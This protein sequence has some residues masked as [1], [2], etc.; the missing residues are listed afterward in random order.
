MMN[1]V[2]LSL[3]FILAST[4]LSFGQTETGTITGIVSDPTG[5]VIPSAKVVVKNR[6]TNASRTASTNS[7][8]SYTFASL[9]AGRYLVSAEFQGFANSQ[10]AVEL[11]LG[12][13]IGLDIQ[14]AVGQTGTTIEVS[15]AVAT[16]NTESQT[17]SE[18]VS[19]RQLLELPSISRDPYAVV[20]T[21]GNVSN[22]TPDGRGVGYSINGQ[23]AASTN[24]L[25]DGAANNDEFGALRGAT[26]PL[27]AVQELTVVT[28]NFTAE[29]GRA[30][31]G[32]VN[33]ATKGGTNQFHGTAYEFNRLSALASNSF[34]NNANSIAKPVFTRNQFG[35]SVGGPVLK[36]KLFFFNN[37][38]WIRVRSAGT[39]NVYVPTPQLLALAAPATQQFFSTFGKLSPNA[40]SLGTFSR[41]DLQSRGFDVCK[42]LAA[43][44]KCAAVALNTPIFQREAFNFPKDSGGGAPQNTYLTVGRV[45]YNMSEKTQMFVRYSLSNE[46][47][48][49]GTISNS[50]YSG[51]NTPNKQSNNSVVYSLTKTLSPS[52]VSQSK[53]DF[54]RFNNQQPY[55]ATYANVPTLFLTTGGGSILGDNTAFPGYGYNSPG[56]GIP[57]GGPQNFVQLYQD[58]SWTKGRHQVRAGG[59]YTY[60]RDNRVFGAYQNAGEVLGTTVPNGFENLLS[61]QLYSFTAAVDPQGKFPCGATVTASCTLS[62]PVGQPDFSRSNRYNDYALYAQDSWKVARRVTLNL[63]VRWEVFGTQHNKNPL[64][65]SNYYF[66]ANVALPAAIANGQVLLAPNSPNGTL[67]NT[68]MGNWAPRLGVAWDVFGDGSTSLRAGYGIGYERN[69][70]N[71][72]FNIIQ[73][74]PNYAVLALIAGTDIPSIPVSVSNAGPLAGS[75]GSKALGKVSLRAVDPNIKT[76][77]AHL[78]S[79]ALEHRFGAGLLAALEYSGSIGENQYGIEN[80]NKTGYGN[81]YGGVPCTPGT[82]G[83]PGSC[84]ARLRGQQFSNINFRTNG[85]SSSYNAMN[86]RL[87]WQGKWGWNFRTNYTWSHTLDT[88]SDTFS[89]GAVANLGWLD[90]FDKSHSLDKGNALFDLRHRFTFA[91]LWDIGLKNP[92]GWQKQ[93]ASGWTLAPIFVANTGAPFTFYDCTNAYTSCPY[94]FANGKIDYSATSLIGTATPNNYQYLSQA[95]LTKN[96]NS[97]WFD[98]KTGISDVGKFPANMIGRNSF[99][100]PGAWNLDLGIYKNFTISERQR[101]QFRAEGYNFFNHANLGLNGDNDVSSVDY[102]SASFRGRRFFQ[103]ALKYIF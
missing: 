6:D 12:S 71:V 51:Y 60:L 89:S 55:S 41:S 79:F 40:V 15:E 5:S 18:T 62:L 86:A 14:L 61:G 93:V 13:R 81:Y 100:G 85:G 74:P 28:N 92:R 70:G 29:F 23:R 57:F 77:Y 90:A 72:T 58:V 84:T 20:G 65:D 7:T 19:T 50:P 82:D 33:V 99:R 22:A 66:D 67:W 35:Y 31:G 94:A 25:L 68:A 102:V 27:D 54:N 69:F 95:F 8:G 10:K 64:K 103:M 37:T 49:D 16:V 34:D 39:T 11:T 47:D 76:A 101:L 38:E 36:N 87:Q 59:S 45:D 63:G 30:S 24:V 2:S 43:T 46:G 52:L 56:T 26:V 78:I 3:A 17:L 1:R 53:V 32:I 83:D 9:P 4:A 88:L 91:G 73:N 42:G 96:F 21:V 97:S 44:S 98:P 48:F 75:T 80:V